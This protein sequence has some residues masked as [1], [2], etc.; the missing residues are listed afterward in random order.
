VTF[1]ACRSGIRPHELVSQRRVA[2]RLAALL[3]CEFAEIAGDAG[4]LTE[5]I[6]YAVPNETLDSIDR[7][8]A[9][10]IHGEADLFGGVVPF[11]FVATKVITHPLVAAQSAAPAGWAPA[12]AERVRDV[13]LPGFSAFSIDDAR[14]AGRRLLQQGDVRLKL[15]TGIGGSGQSVARDETELDA[16]LAA[17]DRAEIARHGIVIE[18]NLAEVRTHS[19]GLLRV[20]ALQASYFGT[21]RLTRNRFGNAV[22][23]GSTLTVA[24]GGLDTLSALADAPDVQR[25]IAQAA[26]YHDAA[27]ACF[28]GMFASRCN[29]DVAQGLDA[30]DSGCSG[31]L[32]QSWRLGGASAAEVVALQVLADQPSRR[33]VRAST[34]EL[35][36]ADADVPEKAIVF[37]HGVDDHLGPIVKYAE[38]H[39]DERP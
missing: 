16:Q 10:G 11:P 38:V 25:A 19:V 28:A 5:P 39:D 21:Q 17:L 36:Q 34:T 8:R 7:A 33:T 35:H 26:V 20:G 18:R 24:R 9:L 29:Y 31:V 6:G 13:V 4:A 12:F 27:L 30:A 37:F 14:T 3:G 23:G 22:Y 2:E 15:A 1:V 32:E